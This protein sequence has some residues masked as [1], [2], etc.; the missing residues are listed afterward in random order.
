VGGGV[1]VGVPAWAWSYAPDGQRLALVGSTSAQPGRIAFVDTRA[2]R[3]LAPLPLS[4]GAVVGTAWLRADRLLV[5]SRNVAGAEIVLVDPTAR[6]VVRRLRIGGHLVRGERVQDEL[7]LLFGPRG[8]IGPSRLVLLDAELGRREIQLRAIRSGSTG[9]DQRSPGLVVDWS[10][11]RAYVVGANEPVAEVDLAAESVAWHVPALRRTAAASKTV[12]GSDIDAWPLGG[13]VIA[14]TGTMYAGLDEQTRRV[15]SVPYGL[16]L[17]DTSDWSF[18][19]VDPAVDRA[20]AEGGWIVPRSGPGF[21]WFD[22]TGAK[23]GQLFGSARVEQLAI[24]GNRALVRTHGSRTTWTVDLPTGR[25]IGRT[26]APPP[27]LLLGLSA[28]IPG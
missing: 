17:I 24:L 5:V 11:P 23:R 10:G 26:A 9:S 2:M 16:R 3:R 12:V 18:R 1:R 15:R 20:V 4:L 21:V 27:R 14:V 19:L 6:R 8:R 13:G 22:R 7:V 25:V 28:P